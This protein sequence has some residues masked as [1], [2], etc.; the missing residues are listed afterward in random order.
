MR[1]FIVAYQDADCVDQFHHAFSTREKAE[2]FMKFHG[3]N[4]QPYHYYIIES[5]LD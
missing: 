4:T 1:I 2:A 5:V 3:Y